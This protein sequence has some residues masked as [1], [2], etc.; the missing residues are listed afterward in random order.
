MDSGDFFLASFCRTFLCCL[1]IAGCGPDDSAEVPCRCTEET[2][3]EL[4][5]HCGDLSSEQTT[6]TTNPFA[7]RIPECPSGERLPLLEPIR[8]TFVLIN[9][10]KAFEGFS[11]I[12]YMDQLTEDFVFVPDVV[13][14][15]L[16]PEVY[17]PPDNYD[18]DRD[19]V[20]TRGQERRFAVNLIDQKRFQKIEFT[21][22]YDLSKDEHILSEDGLR[23]IFI[24]PYEV[25]FTEPPQDGQV[26]SIQVKGRME[27][28]MVTSTVENP[29]WVLQRWQD[30]GDPASAKRSW[31]ELRGEFSP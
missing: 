28:A 4:F 27:V 19:T 23:E 29:V 1:L 24:F 5:P 15:E 7:T 21:R 3:P 22:W 26:K 30:F 16:Y 20:W 14:M 10:R 12:Q 25:E 13:D 11:P 18:P 9:I 31:T 8:A 2:D 6:D 17:Q